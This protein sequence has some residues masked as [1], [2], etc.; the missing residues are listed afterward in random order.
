MLDTET[1]KNISTFVEITM[2]VED[3]LRAKYD[4]E[5]E[6][7]TEELDEVKEE[8]DALTG[9]CYDYEKRTCDLEAQIE[10][11]A[12][13][14]DRQ[15]KTIQELIEKLEA[16]DKRA[17]N[18]I[19]ESVDA[20]AVAKQK[21]E[22]RR[23]EEMNEKLK[24]ENKE[25]TK[26]LKEAEQRGDAV[27]RR[28]ENWIRPS[29]KEPP[30]ETWVIVTTQTGAVIDARYVMGKNGMEWQRSN[31]QPIREPLAWMSKPEPVEKEAIA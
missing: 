30:T 6:R 2:Q 31:Y 9:E 17:D 24:A 13:Q 26:K 28:S 8:R 27:V 5:A 10:E 18:A 14:R 21:E 20:G 4:R 23:L 11:L 19:L 16:T 22:I 12:G 25:L 1:I 3:R 29:E 15:A 7:L